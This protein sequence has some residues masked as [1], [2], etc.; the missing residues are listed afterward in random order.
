MMKLIVIVLASILLLFRHSF[1]Q[2]LYPKR[3]FR[4]AWV[5]TVGNIDWPSDR[6]ATP[7]KQISELVTNFEK[8]KEAGI[9][10]IL[11]QIRTECDALYESELEPWSFWLTAEQGK[12]PK[13][14]FDPLELQSLKLMQGGWNSMLGSILTVR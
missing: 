5:A 13:P 14:F 10:A 1:C 4:G 8:L 3:E 11:F 7:G 2:E 9:N 12:K 6:N